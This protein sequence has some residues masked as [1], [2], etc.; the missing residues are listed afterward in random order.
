MKRLLSILC[1]LT[2][3]SGC[4]GK[5]DTLDRAMALRTRLLG[6]GASFDASVTADYGDQTY[7]FGMSCTL[8]AMGNLEF[9]V[10][11]PE[12][13]SGV[14]GTISAS[15]GKL[16]FSGQALAF[17]LLADG[18]LSPVSGPWI[19][20]HTLRSGY[21]TSCGLEDGKLRLAIDDSY[22][23]DALHLDIWLDEAEMPLRGEILWKGRRILSVTVENFRF[24]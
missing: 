13:I 10:T 17:S 7:T 4:A 3:L 8:D 20:M 23:D 6:S 14:S 12:T 18:Q 15:G 24:V 1:L 16:T 11:Q 5:Q 22:A 21:L 19:L 2:L 9:T